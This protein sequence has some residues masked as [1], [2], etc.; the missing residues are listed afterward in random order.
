M[1]E[2]EIFMKKKRKMIKEQMD[3]VNKRRKGVE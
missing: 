3:E 2:N 1:K